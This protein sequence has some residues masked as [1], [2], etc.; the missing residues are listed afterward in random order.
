MEW[1]PHNIGDYDADTLHLSAFEDG[2][3]TRLLRWYYREERP[4]PDDDQALASIARIGLSE[5]L[6]VS[7]KIRAFFVTAASRGTGLVNL[8][9]K[10]CNKVIA[11]QT[12]KRRDWKERKGKQRKNGLHDPVTLDTP[13]TKHALIVP[14]DTIGTPACVSTP[15][16]RRGEEE[17]KRLEE[18]PKVVITSETPPAEKPPLALVATII[19]NSTVG[20][21]D[22]GLDIP[23]FLLRAAQ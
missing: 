9:H 17:V 5:W 18:S 11:E 4:L 7:V 20:E 16:E 10:R 8:Q 12:K 13:R 2:V 15:E 21:N 14:R 19:K 6:P 23:P 3:Y 1:Y 22:D